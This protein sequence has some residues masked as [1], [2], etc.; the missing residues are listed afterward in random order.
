MSEPQ[1]YVGY[2][3]ISTPKQ[4][5]SLDTQRSMITT[6]V[7]TKGGVLV[8]LFSETAS[9]AK[10]NRRGIGEAMDLCQAE[11][12]LDVVHEGS[13]SPLQLHLIARNLE[14]FEPRSGALW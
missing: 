12:S 11:I 7:E 8:G 4:A 5:T 3:R 10:M 14:G 2:C 1:K 9:G 13:F 6:Y